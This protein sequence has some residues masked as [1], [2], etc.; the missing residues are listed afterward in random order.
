MLSTQSIETHIDQHPFFSQR[1]KSFN[2]YKKDFEQYQID[3]NIILS[4]EDSRC[5]RDEPNK[6]QFKYEYCKY[7]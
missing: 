3:N 6:S 4:T 7:E 2:D 5:L 1:W